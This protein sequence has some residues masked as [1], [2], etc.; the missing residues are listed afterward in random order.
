MLPPHRP[1]SATGRPN[2]TP[3]PSSPEPVRTNPPGGE[4]D[5]CQHQLMTEETSAEK[6]QNLRFGALSLEY[7]SLRQEITSRMGHRSQTLTV[8]VAAAGLFL[9]FAPN[10]SDLSTGTVQLITGVLVGVG[11]VAWFHAGWSV[12]R[13]SRRVAQLESDINY[14]VDKSSGASALLRWDTDRQ[15]RGWLGFVSWMAFGPAAQPTSN[16]LGIE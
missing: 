6:L 7:N 5:W 16:R 10:N 9:S 13:M 4:A 11:V 14:V 8:L 1:A 15:K 2:E 3:S 12:G